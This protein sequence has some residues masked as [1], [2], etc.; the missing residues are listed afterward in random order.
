MLLLKHV[1]GDD[2]TMEDLIDALRD[3]SKLS[4]CVKRLEAGPAERSKKTL[5]RLLQD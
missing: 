1:K 2:V 3:Y 5:A 4:A